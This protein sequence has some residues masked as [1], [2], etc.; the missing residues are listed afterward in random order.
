[1]TKTEAL[2]LIGQAIDCYIEDCISS[3]PKSE[4]QTILKAFRVIEKEVL[5]SNTDQGDK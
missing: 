2:H 5:H 1:M 3:F 4:T